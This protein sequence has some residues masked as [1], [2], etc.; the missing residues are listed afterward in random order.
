MEWV[1][2]AIYSVPYVPVEWVIEA[3]DKF[4]AM[5]KVREMNIDWDV[6]KQITRQ[7]SDKPEIWVGI[8]LIRVE[9]PEPWRG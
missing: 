3:P 6:I 5:K 7:V 2:K 8:K 4:T 9:Q 1:V